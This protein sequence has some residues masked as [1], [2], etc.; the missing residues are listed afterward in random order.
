MKYCTNCGQR[1]SNSPNF[2]GECGERLVE[3][4]KDSYADPELTEESSLE[5]KLEIFNPQIYIIEFLKVNIPDEKGVLTCPRCLG[6]GYVN[7]QDIERLHTSLFWTPGD[8]LYCSSIGKVNI[9]NIIIDT[10]PYSKEEFQWVSEFRDNL[11]DEIFEN[12]SEEQI[13]NFT[14]TIDTYNDLYGDKDPFDT[15]DDDVCE[16]INP[17]IYFSTYIDNKSTFLGHDAIVN[18]IKTKSKNK[19]EY[20]NINFWEAYKE[21]KWGED[22]SEY[23]IADIDSDEVTFNFLYFTYETVLLVFTSA[24][25]QIYTWFISEEMKFLGDNLVFWFEW[26]GVNENN[27]GGLKVLKERDLYAKTQFIFHDQTYLLRFW[28]PKTRVLGLPWSKWKYSFTD[29]VNAMDDAIK[30]QQD[31]YYDS[32]FITKDNK[33]NSVNNSRNQS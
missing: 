8:C 24:D 31:R 10:F 7:E 21:I 11:T 22:N 25:D 13:E 15:W 32:G 9:K 26:D 27:G 17:E 28:K 4:V 23:T 2:C 3:N 5:E 6:D 20:F 19:Q 33:T 14:K 1:L 29:I 30:A 16:S 12:M 18:H